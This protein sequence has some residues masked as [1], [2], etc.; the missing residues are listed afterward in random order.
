MKWKG[1]IQKNLKIFFDNYGDFLVKCPLQKSV[2]F[3]R[4]PLPPCLLV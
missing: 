3:L 1:Q 4:G 2:H